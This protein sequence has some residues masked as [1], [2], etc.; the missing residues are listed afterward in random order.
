[1]S[2]VLRAVDEGGAG[3][4]L[5]VVNADPRG[6]RTGAQ[7]KESLAAL[8]GPL[9]GGRALEGQAGAAGPVWMARE[10]EPEAWG[11]RAMGGLLGQEER[12]AAASLPLLIAALVLA[13]LEVF[14]ARRASHAG[15]GAG[16]SGGL[17]SQGRSA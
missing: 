7:S 14:L 13:L 1:V 4:G 15:A 17:V 5:V 2:G 10:G 16:D 6:G 12:G 8:L 3:R 9:T 11:G